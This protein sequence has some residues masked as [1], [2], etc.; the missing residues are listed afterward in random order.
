MLRAVLLVALLVGCAPAVPVAE[1]TSRVP[2]V[3]VIPELQRGGLFI[4]M[5]HGADKGKDD[6]AVVLADCAT[7]GALTDAGRR[8]LVAMAADLAALRLP[9]GDVLASPYC[10]TLETARLVFGNATPSDVLVRPPGAAA[11]ASDDARVAALRQLLGAV[12][13]GRT[14]TVL[15]THSEVIRAILGLDAIVGES[16]IVRPNVA[17]GY[18]VLAR[19]GVRGWTRP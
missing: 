4:V 12:P 19:I 10:R 8:D 18:T 2:A 17:G 3:E 15:V 7:Q 1:P 16:I 6:P 11:L 5:R 13:Q 9:I 14:D